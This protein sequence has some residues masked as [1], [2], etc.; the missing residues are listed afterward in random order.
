MHVLAEASVEIDQFGTPGSR[1][2]T[3]ADF[4]FLCI[5]IEARDHKRAL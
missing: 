5:I 4:A 1:L 2:P 3:E